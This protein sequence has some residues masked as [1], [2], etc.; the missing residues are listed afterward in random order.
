MVIVYSIINHKSF[1]KKCSV[2]LL[3]GILIKVFAYDFQTLESVE[4]SIVF[5]V[6]GILLIGLALLYPKIKKTTQIEA[7]A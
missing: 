1:L 6:L 3:T 5:L 7:K 2:V 4:R